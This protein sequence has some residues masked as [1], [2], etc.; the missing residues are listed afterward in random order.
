MNLLFLLNNTLDY[1]KSFH[2]RGTT[3]VKWTFIKLS[4]SLMDFS[5]CYRNCSRLYITYCNLHCADNKTNLKALPSNPEARNT[6][7]FKDFV[8]GLILGF[9]FFFFFWN[10][11]R[12]PSPGWPTVSFC[13]WWLERSSPG[14]WM[15]S[16]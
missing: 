3:M 16:S 14:W 2:I 7:K 6:G 4:L 13:R 10:C 9:L 8:L 1:S 5:N 15:P 11:L 12:G